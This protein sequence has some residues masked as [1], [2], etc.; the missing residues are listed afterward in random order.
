MDLETFWLTVIAELTDARDS[1]VLNRPDDVALS[2]QL[3]E[4]I[5][6]AEGR[7]AALTVPERLTPA[8]EA[9]QANLAAA[10]SA[11]S[12]AVANNLAAAA[13]IAAATQL[14]TAGG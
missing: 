4:R 3:T 7:L 10:T 2:S 8:S 13:V 12:L 9:Q 5:A 11:L 14:F 1:I 6:D